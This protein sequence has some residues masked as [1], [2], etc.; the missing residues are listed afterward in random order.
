MQSKKAVAFA[1]CLG[2]TITK[3]HQLAMY[4]LNQP[5][6]YFEKGLILQNGTVLLTLF[7]SAT[8][9]LIYIVN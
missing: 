1:I 5:G 4:Q 9:L 8:E 2:E 6:E 3:S 7:L